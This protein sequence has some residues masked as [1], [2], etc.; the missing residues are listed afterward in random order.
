MIYPTTGTD[1]SYNSDVIDIRRTEVSN[2][3]RAIGLGAISVEVGRSPQVGFLEDASEVPPLSERPLLIA[4]QNESSRLVAASRSA[5]GRLFEV[6]A[7]LKRHESAGVV[8]IYGSEDYARVCRELVGSI[9]SKR[10]EQVFLYSARRSPKLELIWSEDELTRTCSVLRGLLEE[11]ADKVRINVAPASP[12]LDAARRRRTEL[13]VQESWLTG[14]QV[15]QQ[16]QDGD[17]SSPG[18]NNTASRLRRRGEILGAWNGR[19]Y[20]HP[21][22]QFD[23]KTGRLMHEVK[24]L[25]TLLPE[26]PSG[27]RQAFWLFQPHAELNNKR[28]ADLFQ[29]DPKAVIA[30]AQSTFAPA[31]SNW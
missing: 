24:E 26:D 21:I 15:H 16:Q 30:A 5:L 19:E 4:F 17:P 2:P 27:W 1:I 14:G 13:L 3:L 20:L 22:F 6:V 18:A 25:L 28:P 31:N 10:M 9:A 29:K 8:Q 11:M 7:A 23:R 12:A